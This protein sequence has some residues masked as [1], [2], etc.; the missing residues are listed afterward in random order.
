[1]SWATNRNH[2]IWVVQRISTGR[3]IAVYDRLSEAVSHTEEDPSTKWTRMVM[4][5]KK[6]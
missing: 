1:M 6:E 5:H 2:P 4:N 3:V